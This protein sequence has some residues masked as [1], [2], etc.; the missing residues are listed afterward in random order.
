M[1]RR[2]NITDLNLLALERSA[3][4]V[5]PWWDSGNL[6]ARRIK[7]TKGKT[8]LLTLGMREEISLDSLQVSK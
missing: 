6:L 8:Q 2:V 3:C 1:C 5:G 4:T 7:K